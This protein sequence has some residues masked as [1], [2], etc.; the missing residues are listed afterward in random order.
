MSQ[1]EFDQADE[2]VMSVANDHAHPAAKR[3]AEGICNA[4]PSANVYAAE[5]RRQILVTTIQVLSCVLVA[6]LFVA[7]LMDPSIV[8]FLANLG[9]LICGMVAAVK[10]DRAVRI[11]KR[12]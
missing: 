4:K 1:K 3:T 9:V 2:Q 11:W 12:R 8:V 7:A 6:A 10:I 5:L